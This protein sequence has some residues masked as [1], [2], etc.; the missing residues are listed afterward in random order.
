[1]LY[2][3]ITDATCFN[4]AA[5]GSYK[6]RYQDTGFFLDKYIAR[7]GYNA[8]QIADADLNF[9]NNLRVYRFSETLLNAAEL[10]ARGAGSGVV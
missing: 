3:V 2:E 8:D 10:I 4:A 5:A 6:A 7:N 9:N 1:M